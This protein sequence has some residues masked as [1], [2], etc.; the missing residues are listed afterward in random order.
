MTTLLA[1][2]ILMSPYAVAAAIAWAA[3]RCGDLRFHRDQFRMAAP[4]AGRVC[5]DDRDTSR[6]E[7]D[8]DAIR[9]RFERRPSGPPQVRS[10]SAA[11]NVSTARR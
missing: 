9:T 10:G 5:S 2:L 7:H 6:L 11:K 3:H 4:L 1:L 8:L